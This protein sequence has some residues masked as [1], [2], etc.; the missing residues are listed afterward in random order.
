MWQWNDG[1]DELYHYGVLGMKWGHHKAKIYTTKANRA[2]A[3]G[4][5]GDARMHNAKKNRKATA[6]KS[7]TQKEYVAAYNRAAAKINDS[8]NHILSDFNKKW[9]GKYNT[10]AYQQAYIEMF[11]KMIEDEL[12]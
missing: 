7:Y 2:R 9:E 5:M 6:K 8:S 3:R 10:T 12:S 11:S 1:T 4:N